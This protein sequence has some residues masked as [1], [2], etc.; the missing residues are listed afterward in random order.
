MQNKCRGFRCES[1]CFVYRLFS[2]FHIVSSISQCFQVHVFSCLRSWAMK[3]KH[4][5][6][7]FK[8]LKHALVSLYFIDHSIPLQKPRLWTKK[9]RGNEGTE[10]LD[11]RYMSKSDKLSC[12]LQTV[13]WTI[14]AKII[15]AKSMSLFS[16]RT[17]T[18]SQWVTRYLLSGKRN[19]TY[20]RSFQ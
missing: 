8:R 1:F 17:L 3:V 10:H 11:K 15:A 9:K 19:G 2:N 4:V 12:G 14:R 16:C 18:F 6:W 7:W 5:G 13:P 20:L